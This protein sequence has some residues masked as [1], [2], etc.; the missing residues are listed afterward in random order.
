M[1]HEDIATGLRNLGI[2]TEC[3]ACME[4]FYTGMCLTPHTCVEHKDQELIVEFP[5]DPSS[6]DAK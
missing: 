6:G 3:G 1:S 2:D 5:E 4:V